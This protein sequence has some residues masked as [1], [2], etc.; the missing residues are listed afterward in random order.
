MSK[1]ALLHI[2]YGD[3]NVTRFRVDGAWVEGLW[4][5]VKNG[6][7]RESLAWA[8]MSSVIKL[9]DMDEE[10]LGVLVDEYIREF[11]I[12]KNITDPAKIAKLMEQNRP[13]ARLQVTRML[14][15]LRG[16]QRD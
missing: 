15:V 2:E 10:S 5:S 13:A 14:R 1:N 3:G 12:E 11:F 9:D 6:R 4:F 16:G 7:P 8:P